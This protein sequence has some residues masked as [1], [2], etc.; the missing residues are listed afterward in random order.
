LQVN[1]G[2]R[3]SKISF[4]VAQGLPTALFTPLGLL[5]LRQG[6]LRDQFAEFG[7]MSTGQK[8]PLF[9]NIKVAMDGVTRRSAAAAAQAAEQRNIVAMPL[10]APTGRGNILRLDR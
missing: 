6:H 10:R 2:N 3:H 4:C 9:H 7:E 5:H 1:R 8:E